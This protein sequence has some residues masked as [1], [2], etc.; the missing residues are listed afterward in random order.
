MG[1]I[2]VPAFRMSEQANWDRSRMPNDMDS[3]R[4]SFLKSREANY[5]K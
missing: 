5:Y 3:G 4:M 2:S 1:M